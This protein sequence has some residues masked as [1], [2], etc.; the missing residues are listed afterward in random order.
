[1]DKMTEHIIES[2]SSLMSDCN[3][4]VESLASAS[5]LSPKTISKILKGETKP[6]IT[7]LQKICNVFGMKT[8]EFF[9]SIIETHY[10]SDKCV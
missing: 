8:C 9:D 3:L 10:I 7:M 1:M 4:T 6:S 2:I 5:K